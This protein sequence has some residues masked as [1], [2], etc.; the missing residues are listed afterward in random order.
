MTG[1]NMS[2]FVHAKDIG[3]AWLQAYRELITVP[4]RHIVNLAVSIDEPLHEDLGVRGALENTLAGLTTRTRNASWHSVHTV[5]NTIFPISLYRPGR[6][7][8]V[9]RFFERA[10]QVSRL[11]HKRKH[12]WG[13]YI[14]RLIQYEGHD[15]KEINQLEQFLALLNGDTNWADGYEAPLTYPGEVSSA[16]DGQC[17]D[18]ESKAATS[19]LLLIGPDDRRRRGGPCLAHVSLTSVDGSLHLTAL[20]R[21]HHYL[22][23][24][25]GNFLGL[26]RL[27]NF[28]AYESG[29]K[30]G[31]M[32][33]VGTHAEIE[34]GAHREDLTM[35]LNSATVA[36]GD[37]RPIEVAARPLGA[38][39]RD[40]DLP[41]APTPASRP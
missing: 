41:S 10:G 30:V 33:V 27:L 2:T 22:A 1:P 36:Q 32:L 34:P 19:D 15:G 40:L 8:A 37:V 9:Q 38:G 11:H 18:L 39:W 24:A 26:A 13:T 4:G 35:L 29:R 28:L 5:A 17:E 7:D 20:Y 12:E 6:P 25:Y 21:R 31:K 3:D 16:G 14:G 23:R